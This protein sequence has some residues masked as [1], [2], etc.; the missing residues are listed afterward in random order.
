MQKLLHPYAFKVN[1]PLVGFSHSRSLSRTKGALLGSTYLFLPP[2]SP[3]YTFSRIHG[4][5]KLSCMEL[6]KTVNDFSSKV[7][8]NRTNRSLADLTIRNELR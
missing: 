3:V 4:I 6:L 5:C 8:Q 1:G 7:L 2:L